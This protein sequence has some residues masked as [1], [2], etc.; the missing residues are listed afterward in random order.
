M[1]SHYRILDLLQ[2]GTQDVEP[3]QQ[4]TSTIL[5][6]NLNSNMVL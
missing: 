1:K 6:M 5:V 4:Q 2:K 3:P